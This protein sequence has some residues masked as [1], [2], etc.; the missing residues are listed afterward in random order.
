MI[1][2]LSGIAWV[3]FFVLNRT[4]VH[5]ARPLP[6]LRRNTLYVSNHQSTVDTLLVGLATCPPRCWF[7]PRLLPWS[8]AA[9]EVYFRTWVT[10]WFADHLRC[11]PVQ[12]DRRDPTALRSILRVLPGSTAIYFPEGRRSRSGVIGEAAPAAGWIALLSGARVVPVAIDGTNEAVR[13]ERFGLRCFRRIGVSVGPEL[14]LSAYRGREPS[15]AAA[16]EVT[17]LMMAAIARELAHARAARGTPPEYERR[18]S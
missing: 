11:L 4:R 14:D 17:D 10:S 5:R 2:L 16:R 6:P 3:C 13:F 18:A 15:R 12:R 8:L 7:E 1:A 9:A